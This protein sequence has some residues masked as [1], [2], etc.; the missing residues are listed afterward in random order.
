MIR[1]DVAHTYMLSFCILVYKA[2]AQ[3]EPKIIITGS[4]GALGSRVLS[5]LL[6]LLP[7]PSSRLVLVARDPSKLPQHASSGIPIVEGD[8]ASESS[9][10]SALAPYPGAHLFLVSSSDRAGNGLKHHQNVIAAAKSAGIAKIYYTSHQGAAAT[11]A[12]WPAVQ[13]YN[14]EQELEKSGI[15]YVALRNGFYTNTFD[16]LLGPVAQTHKIVAPKDGPV[17]WTDHEDL[18][19][20]TAKILADPELVKD[21][22]RIVYLVNPEAIT[23]EQVAKAYGEAKGVEVERVTVSWGEQEKGLEGAGVPEGARAMIKGIYDAAAAGEFHT[24]DK[25]LERLLEGKG[26]SVRDY[27]ARQK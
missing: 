10:R 25:T 20:A 19:L 6:R 5:H 22:G 17:N 11:S 24:E 3:T 21:N 2:D 14:T 26:V 23:L 1:R 4:T 8:Y 27:F 12:F 7:D 9:F 18:A 16:F 13:H 15:D